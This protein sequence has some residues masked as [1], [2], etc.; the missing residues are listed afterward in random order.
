MKSAKEFVSFVKTLKGDEK[1][2]AQTFLNHF[3]QVFGY[4]DVVSAG[5]VFESRV[6]LAHARCVR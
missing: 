2:E 1:S 3:F 6:E 5:G 4:E